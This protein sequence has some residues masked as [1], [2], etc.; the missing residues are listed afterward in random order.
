MLTKLKELLTAIQTD[1]DQLLETFPKL[2]AEITTAEEQFTT[3]SQSELANQ[4]RISKLQDINRQYLAQIPVPGTEP[5]PATPAEPEVTPE[6][7]A[8]YITQT[9]GGQTNE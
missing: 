4:E 3:L 7:I 6:S 9:L 2:L 8:Q 5:N 1:P